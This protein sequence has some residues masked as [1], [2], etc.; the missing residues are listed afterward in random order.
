MLLTSKQRSNSPAEPGLPARRLPIGAEPRPEGTH[1]RVWAP[2]AQRV[3]VV[4]EMGNRSTKE[5]ALT[6]APDGYFEGLIS[7]V[8]AGVLYRYRLDDRPTLLP[9]PASRFQPEGPQGP[10]EVIDPNSF[11]WSDAGWSGVSRQG[12]VVYEMH[13]GTFTPEGTWGSALEQLRHLAEVGVTVVELLPVADFKGNFGWGY[14]GIHYFAPTRLYGRPDDARRFVDAAHRLGIGVILD[15]VYNHFGPGGEY[16]T[17]F[18]KTYCS[19]RHKTDWGPALNLDD[20]GSAPVREFVLANVAYWLEEFHLDG[21]RVDATQDI[22]D[23]SDEHILTAMVRHARQRFPQRSLYFVA[24]NE[25]QDVR[26]VQPTDRGGHGFDAMWNDDFH[27]SAMVALTG[28]NEAYYMD[29]RGTPQELISACKRGFLYQGQRYAWQKHRR[30]TPTTGLPPWAFVTFLQN[31]DQIANSARGL[32]CHLLTSPGRYRA[33]TALWLLGPGTPMLFQGQEFAASSPFFYFADH[34]GDL[35]KAVCEGRLDFLG[36]FASLKDSAVRD[37]V[38]RPHDPAT[39]QRCKLDPRERTTHAPILALHR[40]LLRLRRDD[41][42]IR[43]GNIDGAVVGPEA[44]VLRFFGAGG[45]DRLLVVNLGRDVPFAPAPEPLLAPPLSGRWQ[46]SFTSE[47]PRY[48][49]VGIGPVETE[50]AGWFFPAHAAVLLRSV[51][52]NTMS[53]GAERAK[54]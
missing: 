34:E 2:A 37:V 24:E 23:D 15:V 26:I 46:V 9:D 21:F 42:A 40:D 51:P 12:Q 30:G 43:A 11:V 16:L 7:D 3:A 18:S 33:L 13:L 1:F 10:S 44:L 39:F 36:Q 27:H 28:R 4:Y 5:A 25:P 6:A 31:H 45:D 41:A 29:Y 52:L 50:E 38:A 14:D 49:G 17:E 19:S 32:R 47:D 54:P 35:A 8:A 22:H 20:D 48:G 53:E